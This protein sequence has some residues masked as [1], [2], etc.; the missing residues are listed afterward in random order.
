MAASALGAMAASGLADYAQVVGVSG[1]VFGLAGGVLWLELRRADQIPA[2]LRI[3]RR[4][5]FLLLVLNA[6]LMAVIPLIAGAAHLGGFAAGYAATAAVAGRA[7]RRA[8]EPIWIRATGALIA[9]V[10]VVAM[11]SAAAELAGERSF[12]ARHAERLARLP[13]I[14][15]FELNDRAW[16]IA[17]SPDPTRE[18][19]EAAL[20]LAERAVFETERSIPGILDTLAEVLFALGHREQAIATIDEAIAMDRDDAYYREQRRRF[21]G[22]RPADDRPEGPF[23]F[24]LPRSEE[25]PSPP[26]AGPGLTV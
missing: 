10:V 21:T 6:A 15:P 19:M 13:G 20:L 18:E 24:F 12:L 23:P 4:A 7:I 3:P 14:S 8:A 17:I 16:Y 22:E 5:F 9:A 26:P 2:W 11:G 1:V 25:P